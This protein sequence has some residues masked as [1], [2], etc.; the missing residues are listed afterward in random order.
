MTVFI[1]GGGLYFLTSLLI[2]PS[3]MQPVGKWACR[4]ILFAAGQRIKLVG[5][6]PRLDEG[7]YIY[8]FNHTSL[9]DTFVIVSLLPEFTGAI[10]KQEQFSV[11][12]WGW[13]LKRWGAMPIDRGDVDE[14]IRRLDRVE[15]S[16]QG[17]LSL[18]IAPEGTRSPD[19]QLG[20]FKKGPF[21]IAVNTKTRVVP[22]VINGAFRAKHKGSWLLRPGVIK[23]QIAPTIEHTKERDWTVTELQ[24]EAHQSISAY[25]DAV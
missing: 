7:P 17:G 20:P 5:K 18:M 6:F 3:R 16:V 4:A 19:G 12:L 15:K 10:G 8:I 21:H 1:L 14:S 2:P 11:P 25:L 24:E 9:L 23:V 22:M 13:I